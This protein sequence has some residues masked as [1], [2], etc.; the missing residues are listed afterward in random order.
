MIQVGTWRRSRAALP[1]TMT[2]CI[3]ATF[4]S[5]PGLLAPSAGTG[6][7]LKDSSEFDCFNR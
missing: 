5:N 3:R 2:A 4:S 1:A 6:N 7:L